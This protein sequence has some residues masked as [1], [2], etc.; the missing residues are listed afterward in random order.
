MNRTAAHLQRSLGHHRQG[1]RPRQAP[2][3]GQAHPAQIRLSPGQTGKGDSDRPR[4]SGVAV[5]GLGRVTGPPFRKD[6]EG[7][8]HVTKVP[9]HSLIDGARSSRAVAVTY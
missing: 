2:H 7:P 1:K 6:R 4:T 3:N 9:T 8:I 5:Q